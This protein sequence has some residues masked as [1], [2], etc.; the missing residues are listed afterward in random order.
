MG[1]INGRTEI[2]NRSQ[3]ASIM[4]NSFVSAMAQFGNRM[5]TSPET[6]AYKTGTYQ[7][8]SGSDSN[9]NNM[10]VAEQNELLRQQ[11]ELLMQILEKPTGISSRDIFNATR[12]EASS[13]YNRTGN[14]PFI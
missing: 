1:H 6:I 5:L 2:L 13:Y 12:S 8:Y 11:N 10:Y 4:N 3:I 9:G 7:T 14:S